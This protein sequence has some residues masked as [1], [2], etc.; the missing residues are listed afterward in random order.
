[1]GA[2]QYVHVPGYSAL[3]LR[4][5]YQDLSLPGAIMDRAKS[6]W[7]PQGVGWSD[8]DKRFTFPRGATITF[9]Y[10]DNAADRYRY[11]SSEFQY[12]AFDEL[13]QF[14]KEWYLYMFSRLRKPVD[15][16]VP[17]RMRAGSNPGGIGHDWVKQRF[18][19]EVLD[20]IDLRAQVELAKYDKG[21]EDI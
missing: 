14:P 11:Q 3:I 10:M 6:W 2:A 1:M 5:T 8:K 4:R 15:M 20:E 19:G 9:G 18:M 21:S 7:V 12:V 17:I 16:P 13:T